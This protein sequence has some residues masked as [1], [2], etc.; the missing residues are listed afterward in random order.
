MDWDSVPPTLRRRLFGAK[1]DSWDPIRLEI[2]FPCIARSN[3]TA[4]EPLLRYGWEFR[5]PR[6]SAQITRP[7]F[8]CEALGWRSR[9]EGAYLS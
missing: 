4:H 8:A 5:E 9:Y 3:S 6:C 2:G 1:T 7:Q